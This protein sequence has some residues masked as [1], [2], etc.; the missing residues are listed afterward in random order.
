MASRPLALESPDLPLNACSVDEHCEA[1]LK[2][3]HLPFWWYQGT[4]TI[5]GNFSIPFQDKMGNWWYQVKPGFAWPVEIYKVFDPAAVKL[6]ISRTFIG[7]QYLTTEEA[8]ESQVV[9]NTNLNLKN[10]GP[11]SLKKD[12]RKGIRKG[13]ARCSLTILEELNEE[14]LDGCML[15]WNNLT[16][17]TGWKQPVKKDF[18]E[19]S[20]KEILGCPGYTIIL[21]R[22]KLSGQI[23][24]FFITKIIGDTICGDTIAV[25]DDMLHTRANDALRYT[26][27]IN[28]ATIPSVTKACCSVKS[29]D[30]D[31][32]NFKISLGYQPIS[33]PAITKLR[34]GFRQLIKHFFGDYYNRLMGQY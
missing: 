13:L 1:L 18:F 10:Y 25:R 19:Q 30:I 17:R 14:V 20:W 12:R 33:F 28:A 32:E 23:A 16:A 15:A 24:G 26:F 8:S 31:L 4:S 3:R 34:F 7:Y 2:I 9:I 21:A 22:E 27:I 5:F 29:N 11:N 6:P